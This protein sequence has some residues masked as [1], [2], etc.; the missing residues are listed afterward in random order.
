MADN[1]NGVEERLLQMAESMSS[2]EKSSKMM[3]LSFT[4]LFTTI[5]AGENAL[6]G[7]DA[8]VNRSAFAKGLDTAVRSLGLTAADLTKKEREM[9]SEVRSMQALTAGTLALRGE[10]L[11][12]AKVELTVKELQ[13]K[14]T[15]NQLVLAK[16]LQKL[17]PVSSFW[18]GLILNSATSLFN[19]HQNIQREMQAGNSTLQNRIQLTR[20]V[21]ENQRQTG[22][23]LELSREA[24][25]ELLDYGY[26][27]TGNLEDQVR[28]VTQM[29]D[30]LG[31]SMRTASEMAAVYDRQLNVSAR[32]VAN[33]IANV[34]NDTALA[35]DEA[36]RLAINLGRAVATLRPGISQDLAA[37]NELVGRYEGSLAK[38]GGQFGGFADLLTKMTTSEGM[39]QAGLLG[40]NN[41]EFLAS[42]QATKEVLNS[43]TSY[44]KSFLGDTAGWERALR[45]QSLSEMF[46]T[47]TQQI[48]LM[49]KAAEEANQVRT[50]SLTVEERYRE[51]VRASAQ[52]FDRLGNSIRSL[53]QQAVVPIMGIVGSIAN[54]V[55]SGIEALVRMPGAV[56]VATTT[57]AVGTVF[58]VRRM[59][60]VGVALYQVATSAMTATAALRAQALANSTLSASSAST[61][62]AGAVAGS[63]ANLLNS[64]LKWGFGGLLALIGGWEL[65]KFINRT[66]GADAV[67]FDNNMLKESFDETFRRNIRFHAAR[68]D[69]QGLR[70]D[71]ESFRRHYQNLGRDAVSVEGKLVRILEG[72]EDHVGNVRFAKEASMM[73]GY[74][75]NDEVAYLKALVDSQ[76]KLL[77]QAEKQRETAL[78]TNEVHKE[79]A[80]Q[81][82]KLEEERKR[83]ERLNSLKPI[84]PMG[85]SKL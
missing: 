24:T 81:D 21:L 57:F 64:T 22:A 31:M 85:S 41:P 74:R 23:S 68:G 1:L 45:L 50:G 26:D 11:E 42:E 59:Y 2:M 44:A 14:V 69:E 53:T 12:S 56:A 73:T 15:A 62:V 9:A 78:K 43:F 8:I 40:V 19:T 61:A 16:E 80:R 58:M 30:G 33:S 28:L 77:D 3:G 63:P 66:W 83:Q 84:F 46:G 13:H 47:S 70:M 7:W 39:L 17:N 32:E 79:K 75:S 36:G 5:V 25:R 65:G 60:G 51:Q 34:V 38:L 54:T 10:A 76:K 4:Q 6:K 29:H 27:L 48:N 49:I 72:L 52:S 55:A 35:A 82:E 67:K 18:Y 37:V 71:T 20:T